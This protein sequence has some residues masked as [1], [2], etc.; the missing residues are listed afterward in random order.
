M[1]IPFK[2]SKKRAIARDSEEVVDKYDGKYLPAQAKHL[3]EYPPSQ[4]ADIVINNTNW[5]YPTIK[6]IRKS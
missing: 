3:E 4:V 1:D 2:E 5:E 6:H